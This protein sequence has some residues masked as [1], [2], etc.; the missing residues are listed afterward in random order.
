MYIA[1]AVSARF[2][3]WSIRCKM[4]KNIEKQVMLISRQKFLNS[5]QI[6]NYI[7]KTSN[8][9]TTP[10]HHKLPSKHIGRPALINLTHHDK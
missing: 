8:L 1:L 6:Q 3:N 2:R 4:A 10:K 9:A 5:P 7:P